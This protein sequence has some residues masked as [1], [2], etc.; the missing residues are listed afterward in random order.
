[1]RVCC[2]QLAF[3]PI[4]P[5]LEAT[6]V[7]AVRFRYG[8][9]NTSFRVAVPRSTSGDSAKEG[10]EKRKQRAKKSEN[11]KGRFFI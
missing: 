3:C 8:Q 2:K 10:K 11:T 5:N 9:R 7:A 4:C 6:T 1:M